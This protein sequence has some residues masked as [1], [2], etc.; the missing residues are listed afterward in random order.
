[1]SKNACFPIVLWTVLAAAGAGALTAAEPADQ[2]LRPN[3]VVILADDLGYG[4]LGCYN[5]Q[6]KIPTPNLDRLAGDGMR[7]IDAHAPDAVC[8]PTR[9]GL[10]TGRYSFRSRLKAGVLPPWGSPLIEPGRLTVPAMLGKQGYATACIGKWHLGWSWPTKD[11][12]TPSSKDG[13]G[14]VDFSKPVLDGPTSRGFDR[15]FGVD[16]PNYPPYCFIEND[17]TVGIPSLAAPM[18]RGGFNRPG[19]MVAGWKLVDILPELTRQSVRYVEDAAK[20]TP[21]RPF[22][23][24]VPLTAPHYPVV[25]TAQFKGR[26]QAGDYGD[27]VAQVDGT[28]GE[29]LGALKRTGLAKDTLVVFTSDN[30]PECVEIDPGAYQRIRQYGHRSMDGLRGV[31]RDVWE[32]GHRVPFLARWPGRIPAGRTSGETICHVDLMAT[33]AAIVGTPIPRDAGEDSYNLLPALVGEKLD[34]PIRE[35]TVLHGG[36]GKFAIRQGDWVLIEARTGDGNGKRGEPDWFKRERGYQANTLPG[37]LY[38]LRA[39][40]AQR[41]NLYAQQPEVVRRLGALLEKYRAEGRSTPGGTRTLNL[42]IRSPL[43]Y[44]IEL[45]AQEL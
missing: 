17:R 32:G 21:Q 30:G 15:Y 23:L 29:I 20:A 31:K 33:C 11:G 3:I 36:D 35:A 10:L 44:P 1:M 42:R 34:H 22:F 9:Y 18:Q 5:A 19:P 4:D 25:P 2:P 13:V 38:D 37:E 16:L 7:F 26:S 40:L 27:F 39:D 8:T 12:R 45:R 41:R 14:N 28:V 6:S 24:Y 43:L